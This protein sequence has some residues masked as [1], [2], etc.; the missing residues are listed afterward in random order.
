MEKPQV[1]YKDGDTPVSPEELVKLQTASASSKKSDP[2]D[3]DE[4]EEESAKEKEE[5]AAKEKEAKEKKEKEDA[6]SEDEDEK[7]KLAAELKEKEDKD[8]SEKEKGEKA[9]KKDAPDDKAFDEIISKEL[10]EKYEIKSKKQLIETLDLV[11]KAATLNDSLKK[12]LEDVKKSKTEIKFAS[13]DHEAAYN[14]IKDAPKD[15]QPERLITLGELKKID[16]DK[17]DAKALM[18]QKYIIMHPEISREDAEFKFDQFYDRKYNPKKEDFDSDEKFAKA[19]REAKISLTTSKVK[20][21]EFLRKKQESYKVSEDK[22]PEKPK[23]NEAVSKSIVQNSKEITEFIDKLEKVDIPM[24]EG[25]KFSY[26]LSEEMRKELRTATAWVKNPAYYNEKGELPGFSPKENTVSAIY[27]LF[28]DK[29][30]PEIV[31]EAQKRAKSEQIEEAAGTQPNRTGKSGGEATKTAKSIDEQNEELIRQK[32][33]K[34]K[35]PAM[36]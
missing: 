1:V 27:H 8:K 2:D 15:L 7:E 22:A 34:K 19:E 36:A 4:E 32:E 31:K 24:G 28:H 5:L 11:D 29:L 20:A 33:S 18:R 9:K 25:K 6:D 13:K 14:F 12:E 16:V 26:K 3:E 10:S 17:A 23:V 21:Q 35:T 30:I